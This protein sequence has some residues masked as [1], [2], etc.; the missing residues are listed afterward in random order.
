MKETPSQLHARG[1]PGYAPPAW[2]C[3]LARPFGPDD[4]CPTLFRYP[5]PE[6]IFASTQGRLE[7][8]APGDSAYVW[9]SR[10]PLPGVPGCALFGAVAI[11]EP[12]RLDACVAPEAGACLAVNALL[13]PS[14][15][16]LWIPPTQLS[17]ALPWDDLRTPAEVISAYGAEYASRRAAVSDLVAAYLEEV[18]AVERAGIPSGDLSWCERSAR[19]RQRLLA[20]HGL[21]GRFTTR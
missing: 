13:D 15:D 8:L 11:L 14:S 21:R 19:E 1:N 9:L 12:L 4:P 3:A 7:R 6:G 20:D 10:D 16:A 18:D 5:G 17:A 2:L